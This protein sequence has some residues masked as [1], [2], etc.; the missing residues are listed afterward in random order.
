MYGTWIMGLPT[1]GSSRHNADDIG[2]MPFPI[3]V[4]GEQYASA[5]ADYSYGI[6]VNASDDEKQAALVFVKWMTE[7]S[8]YAYNEDSL[9]IV[10]GSEYKDLI[11]RC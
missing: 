1:D 8:G 10:P 2:Y 7:K 6:N 9:A 5:G 4:N 3:S 11:R